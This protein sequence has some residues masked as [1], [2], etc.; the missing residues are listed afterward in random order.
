MFAFKLYT[1]AKHHNHL[2]TV[3]QLLIMIIYTGIRQIL[4]QWIRDIL[5]G[6]KLTYNILENLLPVC[7]Q[8]YRMNNGFQQ[9]WA[10]I[11]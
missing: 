9:M 5:S 2:W 8:P 6:D 4:I 11:K 10:E 7:D 3:P 1:F